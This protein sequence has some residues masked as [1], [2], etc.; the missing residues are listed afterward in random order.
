MLS[1]LVVKVIILK[2]IKVIK[3]RFRK[4]RSPQLHKFKSDIHVILMHRLL[5]KHHAETVILAYFLTVRVI[6]LRIRNPVNPDIFRILRITVD[7]SE[8]SRRHQGR[9]LVQPQMRLLHTLAVRIAAELN[10]IMDACD[11]L[12][13]LKRFGI[14]PRGHN[15]G[16]AVICVY[17][18]INTAVGGGPDIGRIMAPLYKRG[19]LLPGFCNTR[20]GQQEVFEGVPVPHALFPH[21]MRVGKPELLR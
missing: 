16:D 6:G 19:E 1:L 2:G 20:C 7:L 10:G 15:G 13:R 11:K 8:H 21:Y 9:A 4:A 18:Y 3:Q 12:P 5:R 17:L 14:I